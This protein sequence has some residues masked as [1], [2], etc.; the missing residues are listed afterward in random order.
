M[1]SI[2]PSK[3][4]TSILTDNL[5]DKFLKREICCKNADYKAMRNE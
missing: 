5:T 1:E 3:Q 4:E 2:L